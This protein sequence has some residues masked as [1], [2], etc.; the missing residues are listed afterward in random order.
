MPKC[1]YLDRLHEKRESPTSV[2]S[3]QERP[4]TPPRPATPV[5]EP[6]STRSRRSGQDSLGWEADPWRSPDLHRGHNH[7]QDPGPSS[8]NGYGSVRSGANAWSDAPILDSA[9][10]DGTNGNRPNGRDVTAPNTSES[11]W[12]G[13]SNTGGEE[14]GRSGLGGFGL[15]DEHGDS[16][17]PR[18]SLGTGASMNPRVEEAVT[19]TLLP[20]K[21]GVFMFQHRNYEIKSTRRGS[22]VIRRYSDFVWLLDCLQKR[23]PFRQLPL[24]PPKRIAGTSKWPS[25]RKSYS[26]F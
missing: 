20:E 4:P 5:Q 14:A 15:P 9:Q 26:S 1:S 22:T 21:E 24:L 3:S 25:L 23:Y 17:P 8:L 13:L 12:S 18:R 7:P 11:G 16:T 19:V 10:G 6:N 2:Q